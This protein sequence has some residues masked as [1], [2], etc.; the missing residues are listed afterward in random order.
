MQK[1]S[2]TLL[3]PW[4]NPSHDKCRTIV[5]DVV[6]QPSIHLSPLLQHI[7]CH[8]LGS[9]LLQPLKKT[10]PS[11]VAKRPHPARRNPLGASGLLVKSIMRSSLW[12][13]LCLSVFKV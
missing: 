3:P 9:L 12:R 6:R 13:F 1:W 7:L 2:G 4:E 10:D 11:A 5:D 8:A